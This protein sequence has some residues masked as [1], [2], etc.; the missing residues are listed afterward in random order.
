MTNAQMHADEAVRQK[1]MQVQ[2]KADFKLKR[3][4]NVNPRTSTKR[5]NQGYMVMNSTQGA[6]MT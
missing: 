5:G 2:P 4:Q 6:S 1:N 3:F